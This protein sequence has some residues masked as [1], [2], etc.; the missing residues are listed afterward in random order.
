MGE[1]SDIENQL[2]DIRAE[3]ADQ[4][5]EIKRL[6]DEASAQGP[7]K[8]TSEHRF[9]WP[10][11]TKDE[12][13]DL[14]DQVVAFAKM[15]VRREYLPEGEMMP[16]WYLHPRLLDLMTAIYANWYGSYSKK[17]PYYGPIDFQRKIDEDIRVLE[18]MNRQQ[19]QRRQTKTDAQSGRQC[20]DG[21]CRM[22]PDDE[23]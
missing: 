16:C 12:A 1:L 13:S 9:W 15:L 19:K 3:Q 21:W 8:D 5:A 22:R 20:G 7:D 2:A 6:K 10:S 18:S 23:Q 14:W 17:G 4:G 11:L